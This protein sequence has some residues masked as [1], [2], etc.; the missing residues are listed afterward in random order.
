MY[1]VS[2]NV[3]GSPPKSKRKYTNALFHDIVLAV[4]N[5]KGHS[6]AIY[7]TLALSYQKGG[8]QNWPKQLFGDLEGWNYGVGNRGL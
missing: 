2:Y 4:V 1:P 8:T 6:F 3:T 7:C 5:H